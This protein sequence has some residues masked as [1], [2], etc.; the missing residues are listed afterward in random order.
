MGFLGNKCKESLAG[1]QHTTQRCLG[2]KTQMPEMTKAQPFLTGTMQTSKLPA[3]SDIQVHWGGGVQSNA[4]KYD[5]AG[6]RNEGDPNVDN[7]GAYFGK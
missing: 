6:V 7:V 3:W 4:Y 2:L 1:N 5:S